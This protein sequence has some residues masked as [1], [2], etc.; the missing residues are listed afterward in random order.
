MKKIVKKIMIYSM[1]G[2]MQLGLGAT[3]IEASPLHNDGPDMQQQDDRHDQ[4]RH[5]RER[6]ERE[7]HEREMQRRHHES[8]RE[9]HDRQEREKQR[10]D[11]T[12]NEIAAGLIGIVIGSQI[13]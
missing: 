1:V 7:R 4:D 10:H 5:E 8:E 13:N 9:W 3:V 2:M 12:M 6:H 11:N